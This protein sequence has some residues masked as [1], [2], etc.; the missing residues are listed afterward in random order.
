MTHSQLFPCSPTPTPQVLDRVLD[1]GFWAVRGNHDE[2]ALQCH[3]KWAAQQPFKERFSWVAQLQARHVQ[4]LAR[5]PFSLAVPEYGLLVVHAGRGMMKG[6]LGASSVP[7][8]WL[9]IS[10][11]GLA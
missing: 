7:P 1:Q 8:P 2:A 3:S 11:T 5:L 6:L 10:C 4:L 9:G